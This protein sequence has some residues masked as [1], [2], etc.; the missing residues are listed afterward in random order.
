MGTKVVIVGFKVTEE[1]SIRYKKIPFE[2]STA[3]SQL[4]QAMGQELLNCY[5]SGADFVSVRFTK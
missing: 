1:N 4:A 3:D 2:Q 5:H